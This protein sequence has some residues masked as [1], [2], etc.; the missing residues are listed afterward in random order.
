MPK[1]G[2]TQSPGGREMLRGMMVGIWLEQAG[3]RDEGRPARAG[4][5]EKMR[6]PVV[7]QCQVPSAIT[8][9]PMTL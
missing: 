9:E 7:R 2:L 6:E 1:T 5:W 3:W 4:E 8:S